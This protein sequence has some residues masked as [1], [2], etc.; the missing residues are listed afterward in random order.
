MGLPF[1]IVDVF[2]E[3]KYSGNQ[4]AVFEN[5]QNLSTK[6][7]QDIA[8]EINFAESTFITKIDAENNSAEMRIFTPEF[9]MKFAGHP[10]IGTSWVIMNIINSN[11]SKKLNLTVPV[12]VIPIFQEEE[13]VWLQSA[14]PEFF[15]TFST[16]GILEFSN[17]KENDFSSDFPIQEVSTG[18]AFVIVPLQNKSALTNLELNS[19]KM[20]EWLQLNCK[21]NFRAL[22]FFCLEEGNIHSRMLYFEN[23]QLKEDAATGS[24]STCLQAFLLKYYSTDLKMINHQGDAIGRPSKIYFDGK[25]TKNDFEI[26]IGGQTQFIAKGEWEV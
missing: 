1:Y 17:L 23:N 19:A 21:T 22:Y 18:S 4:L 5:A 12:G 26:K 24:A 13:M 2:A 7:M 9:E 11:S 14:Q 6:E 10:I 25:F 16:D 8:T 3:K 20:N 15:N